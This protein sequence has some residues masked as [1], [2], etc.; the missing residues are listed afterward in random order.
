MRTSRALLW[1]A[2]TFVVFGTLHNSALSA[3]RE[4]VDHRAQLRRQPGLIQQVRPAPGSDLVFP[5]ARWETDASGKRKFHLSGNLQRNGAPLNIVWFV[6]KEANE[7]QVFVLNQIDVD[8]S[9]IRNYLQTRGVN[10]EVDSLRSNLDQ[11]Y[12]PIKRI[13]TA[14]SGSKLLGSP[15]KVVRGGIDATPSL[16]PRHSSG[17]STQDL[18]N[19]YYYCNGAASSQVQTWDP[20]GYVWDGG[21]MTDQG[22]G[23]GWEYII[24][25]YW[26]VYDYSGWVDTEYCWA[27]PQSFM[28][29]HW[30]VEACDGGPYSN[31]D[32]QEYWIIGTYLNFDFPLNYGAPVWVESGTAVGDDAGWEPWWDAYYDD[33]GWWT[34]IFI[35]GHVFGNA[36]EFCDPM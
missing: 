2:G 25:N 31:G 8:T 10:A 20:L 4:S 22:A 17:Y 19:N 1:V 11:F 32:N 30:Y 33:G 26:N 14:R 13:G 27:N 29:T 15:R 5:I 36:G 9:R 3:A 35:S 7:Y 28:Y 21:I 16:L 34:D 6:D 23:V 12:K 24:D 18:E